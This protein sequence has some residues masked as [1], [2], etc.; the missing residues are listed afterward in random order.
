MAEK[1]M[2][3]T[4]TIE[5]VEYRKAAEPEGD[6]RIVILQRGWIYVGSYSQEGDEC[7][8]TN[9]ACIRIWGTTKGLTE[10]CEGPTSKTILD[11]TRYPVRFHRLTVVADLGVKESE[12]K[13]IL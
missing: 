9:A 5:G 8:L 1:C 3:D 10:L 2:P 6:I 4:V 11:K 7:M 13:H 12:W